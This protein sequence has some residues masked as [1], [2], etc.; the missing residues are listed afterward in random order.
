[1]GILDDPDQAI[2]AYKRVLEA[3]PD[4]EAARA[5]L[6]RVYAQ[7]E[8]WDDLIELLRERL[9]RTEA[10]GEREAV[11]LHIAA[12]QEDKLG[13]VD[14]ALATVESLLAEQPADPGATEALERMAE[15]HEEQR[16]RI[17]SILRPIYEATQNTLR[18]M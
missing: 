8:R 4:H 9:T 13:S 7:R 18:L 6:E 16:V 15:A 2:N 3:H 10:P 12:L 11:L 5:R 14:A 1:L 17:F